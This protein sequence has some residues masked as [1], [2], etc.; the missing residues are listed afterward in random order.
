MC[1]LQKRGTRHAEPDM[2]KTYEEMVKDMYSNNL[3]NETAGRGTVK[4]ILDAF[5]EGHN[6][7]NDKGWAGCDTDKQDG[8]SLL[9]YDEEDLEEGIDTEE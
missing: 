9:Y 3:F 2:T 8:E 6:I 7:I 4:E 5:E 1:G